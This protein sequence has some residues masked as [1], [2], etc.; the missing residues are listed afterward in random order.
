MA[1]TKE[2]LFFTLILFLFLLFDKNRE[3]VPHLISK[4]I[5]S[6]QLVALLINALAF[7]LILFVIYQVSGVGN[8]SSKDNFTFELTPEKRC[9]GGPYMYSD[10]PEKLAFCSQFSPEDMSRFSCG[11]GFH[12]APVTFKRDDMSDSK[13]ENH[14]CDN[15]E[16]VGD[17]VL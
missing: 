10:D 11:V 1:N 16:A 9:E 17:A 3:V 2:F 8:V 12:G 13:W 6:N 7:T 15:W 5:D 4:V 14:M